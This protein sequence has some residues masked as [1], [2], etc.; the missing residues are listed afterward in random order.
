MKG[1]DGILGATV[2]EPRLGAWGIESTMATSD[3]L[4]APL[5]NRQAN[6][7]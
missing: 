3:L 7:F 1:S 2:H 5:T 4:T 6:L